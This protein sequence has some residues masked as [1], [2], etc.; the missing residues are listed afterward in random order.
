MGKPKWGAK[1][2][3]RKLN[4]NQQ[5]KE[6]VRNASFKKSQKVKELIN[7]AVKAERAKWK[8]M[9]DSKDAEIQ[10]KAKS[11]TKHMHKNVALERT[12]QRRWIICRVAL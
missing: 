10:A 1:A 7:E 5:W 8:A 2:Y 4:Y 6:K 3:Y 9:V 12:P 11:N